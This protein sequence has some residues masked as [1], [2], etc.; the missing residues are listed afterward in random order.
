MT[1]SLP[2]TIALP[3]SSASMIGDQH[4]FVDELGVR[5]VAQHEAF[6]VVADG[7]ADHFLGDLQKLF[8]ERAHQHHRPF[9]EAG[10]FG[11]QPFV[12]D[13][14]EPLREGKLLGLGED[15]VA[16][17]L[18]VEHHLGLVELLHV[19]GEPAHR[20][21][22][23]R[24]K[25]V[26]ARLVAGGDAV[27]GKR[28]DVRILGLRPERG[29]DRMQRP[30]PGQRAGFLR[31]APQRID[32]GHGK[33]LI[34]VGQNFAD[35]VERRPA[36]FLDHRDIEVALLVGLHLGVA[37][38]FQSRGFQ[39]AG[40]G[41]LGRADARALFLLAQIGLPRRHAVHR[42]RQPPRRHERLGAV[43]ER[44]RPRPAGR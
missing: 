6:L 38:R 10:D 41:V 14:F 34:T 19:I 44:G 25:A 16:P 18:G 31:R 4:E 24:E 8:V 7:G 40:D 15:D 20:E 3:P 26:A 36:R 5:R 30:H 27:D 43:I 35:H 17:P 13:Q 29:D 28:H 11:Q 39:K 32:F 12:L 37:D 1:R 22:L 9:D 23:R 21:R 33:V 2:A 42:E